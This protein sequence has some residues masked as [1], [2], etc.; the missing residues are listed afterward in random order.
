MISKFDLAMKTIHI[1]QKILG[2]RVGSQDQ[3]TASVGGFNVL[4]FNI[5]GSI[6]INPVIIDKKRK[7]LLNKHLLLFFTGISRDSQTITKNK[8]RNIELDPSSIKELSNL[9]EDAVA[10]LASNQDI[11]DFGRLL[12]ETWKLKRAISDEI[13]NQK[14][15]AIYETALK[16]GAVG[17]KL[18]GAGGGGFIIFFAPPGAHSKIAAA[19]KNYILVPFKF[20]GQGSTVC[21]YEPEGFGNDSI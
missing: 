2:E 19:L 17:G 11:T 10:I 9:V 7:T 4:R 18:L 3:V 6:S 8:I 20:E 15:D 14:I 13:S 21:L 5:D 16:N 12:H 1:E